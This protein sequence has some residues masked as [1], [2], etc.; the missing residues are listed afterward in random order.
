MLFFGLI[1]FCNLLAVAHRISRKKPADLKFLHNVLFG[2]KG[3]VKYG[4]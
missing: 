2:R 3:K 1:F 4:I